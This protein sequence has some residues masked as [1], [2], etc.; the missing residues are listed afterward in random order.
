MKAREFVVGNHYLQTKSYEDNDTLPKVIT[1][2]ESNWYALGECV[3]FED[4]F[5]PIPLTEEWLIK[6][7]WTEEPNSQFIKFWSK[8]GVTITHRHD[9]TPS[10][11]TF[12]EFT[13]KIQYVHQLESL[14]YALTGEELTPKQ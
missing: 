12:M 11:F 8:S 4:W 6:F 9:L 10:V 2:Q 5:E 1:W 7:G 14:Y 3:E 13:N